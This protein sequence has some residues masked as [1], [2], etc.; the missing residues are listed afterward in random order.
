M[1]PNK[2]I[3]NYFLPVLLFTLGILPIFGVFAQTQAQSGKKKIFVMKISSEI[4]AQTNRYSQLALEKADEVNADIVILDLDTYGGAL[5]DADEIRKRFLE[6][7]KPLYVF[8]DK[9]AASAG[10]L[11]SIACD[12]IY[13]TPGASIGAATVVVSTGEAAPDKYQSYMRS[14][15]LV[16]GGGARQES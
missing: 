7:D 15:M 4:N 8:I 6:F 5:N 11:I 9:N 13:M 2:H 16:H 12:S 1:K 14:I 3:S 10:A